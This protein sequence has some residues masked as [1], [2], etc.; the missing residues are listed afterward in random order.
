MTHL[1][2]EE[3]YVDDEPISGSVAFQN[4]DAVKPLAHPMRMRAYIEAVKRPVSAKELSEL[5]DVPLQRMSYH[6]RALADAGLLRVVRRTPRRGAME[7]H[8][9]AIATLEFSDEAEAASSPEAL[10]FWGQAQVRWLAEEVLHAVEHDAASEDD[11][12]MSRAHFVVDDRGRERLAAELRAF[13]RRLAELE[14]ELRVEP[15]EGAHEI[16]VML[17]Q[18]SAPRAGGRQGPTMMGLP[19]DFDTIPPR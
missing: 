7:T 15:G 2:P 16:N 18:Y 8:Y 17:G 13:Y 1:E 5:M 12:F 4:M 10:M 19:W 14:E 11:F 9:R 3:Q 6:V